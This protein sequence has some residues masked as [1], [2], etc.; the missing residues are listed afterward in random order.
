M[1]LDNSSFQGIAS[2]L[3]RGHPRWIVVFG[4]YA[5]QFVAFP[6]FNV[7]R[8][9]ILTAHYP[10]ALA[11]RMRETEHKFTDHQTKNGPDTDDA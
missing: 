7:P 11:D 6:R 10:D 5:R 3:E 4:V 1:S 9:T 2:Q 8:G